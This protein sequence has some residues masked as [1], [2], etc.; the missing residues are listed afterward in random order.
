LG[1][2]LGIIRDPRPPG[3]HSLYD[4]VGTGEDGWRNCETE[5]VGRLQVDDQ[6]ELGRLLNREISR[7]GSLQDAVDE[8]GQSSRT[9]TNE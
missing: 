9:A 6:F 3:P 1:L 5:H 4:L 8:I 7:L 2:V